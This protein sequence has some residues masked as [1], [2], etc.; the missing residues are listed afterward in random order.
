MSESNDDRSEALQAE[1]AEALM[2]YP[3][4]QPLALSGLIPAIARELGRLGLLSKIDPAKLA[5][6]GALVAAGVA[7]I[8]ER[9]DRSA[10]A[11]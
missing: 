11:M 10:P 1:L 5:A 8:G 9:V 7:A 2:R 4:L 3:Q 6:Y